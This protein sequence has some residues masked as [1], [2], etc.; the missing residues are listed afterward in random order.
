MTYD[1][2]GNLT[3]DGTNTYTWD[4]RGHLSTLAGTNV[5]AYQYDAFGRRTQNTLNGVMTQL[6]VANTGISAVITPAGRVIAAT[7][8]FTRTTEIE[9]VPWRRSRTVCSSLGDI[10]AELCLDASLIAL[11]AVFARYRLCGRFSHG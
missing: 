5:A 1:A 9:N 6:R 7:K 10:F 8:I 4:A 3:N 2:D 11:A